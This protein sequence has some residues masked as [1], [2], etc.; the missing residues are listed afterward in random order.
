MIHKCEG[1]NEQLALRKITAV[2]MS[3]CRRPK[4]F[5]TLFQNCLCCLDL[6]CLYLISYFHGASSTAKGYLKNLFSS[7]FNMGLN[8]SLNRKKLETR[9]IY[10]VIEN[11]IIWQGHS[12][13]TV[14]FIFFY[15]NT[16]N[17][18]YTSSFLIPYPRR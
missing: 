14:D 15:W 12:F 10:E 13:L 7:H 6:T 18:G 1:A 4:R 8:H 9:S 11:K 16:D 3:W 17:S 2:I 5:D